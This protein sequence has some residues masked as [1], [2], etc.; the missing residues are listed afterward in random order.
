MEALT[1]GV[2]GLIGLI[3]VVSAAAA[4][5]RSGA[6]RGNSG[7]PAGGVAVVYFPFI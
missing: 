2:A 6:G 1:D 3:V 7:S 5:R 4:P